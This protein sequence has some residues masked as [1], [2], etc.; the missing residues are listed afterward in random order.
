L[1][2]PV[3]DQTTGHLRALFLLLLV[4]GYLLYSPSFHGAWVYDDNPAIVANDAMDD[5]AGMAERALTGRRT[6]TDFTFAL[7]RAAGG[8]DPFGYHLV[9][10][11]IHVLCAFF[12]ALL[13]R[14]AAERVGA[15]AADAR[16]VSTAAGLL[17]LCHPLLSQAVAYT[18]QRYTSLAT[19]FYLAALE[20]YL[21]ARRRR[22]LRLGIVSF[23]CAFLSM[24]CKEIAFTLPFAL[25]LSE[26][27]F[28][29][30]SAR[31]L[32]YAA[33]FLLLLPLI[34]IS[35]LWSGEGTSHYL[36]ARTLGS[37]RETADI[38]RVQYL[39]TESVVLLRYL[40]LL[41]YPSGLTVERAPTILTGFASSAALAATAVLLLLSIA[42]WCT[43][44]SFPLFTAAWAWFILTSSVE[45]SVIPIRDVMVEHRMYLPSVALLIAVAFALAKIPRRV[46]VLVALLLP[47]SFG[48]WGRARTWSDPVLLWEDAM[49]KAPGNAR[50]CVNLALAHRR[51]GR[52]EKAIPLYEKAISLD[53][54]LVEAM[55]GLA[56]SL[57]QAGRPEEA[58][59]VCRRAR[60]AAADY[61]PV[62]DAEAELLH[63]L[64]RTEEAVE[65]LERAVTN[66]GGEPRRLHLLAD[67]LLQLGEPA[68]SA[69]IYRRALLLN[70]SDE[71]AAIG[72]A[73]ALV[74]LGEPG[75]ALTVLRPLT[76][77]QG[78]SAHSWNAI[79][80]VHMGAGD[81]P[82]ARSA[83]RRAL[84]LD[85]NLTG[86]RENLVRL[87]DPDSTPGE[88]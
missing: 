17:F 25:M 49:S 72:L 13:A 64:G 32:R 68:A 47:L 34:P 86:A 82:A 65:L 56:L 30:G 40:M 23:I 31:K 14:R 61:G 67:M 35:L 66:C 27:F 26:M 73:R 39:A 10:I 76:A 5:T 9:N 28:Y 22:S 15:S 33:P 81:R 79:G 80:M 20:F 12:V 11:A 85:P 59:E 37:F 48:T 52:F 42:A 78:A 51:A 6:L 38:G 21:A 54:D 77:R 69:E 58:I 53:R 44:R 45:S 16:F 24:R 55:Y 83:F 84:D 88:R 63:E 87:G 7:N 2:S 41:L 19:L 46:V 71:R 18:A 62:Y 3:P 74:E 57:R 70:G 60:S 43:R 36:S 1:P 50:P 29:P 8:L 75:S 4:V